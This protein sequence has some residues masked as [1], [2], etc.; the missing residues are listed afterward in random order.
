MF[1]RMATNERFLCLPV[2]TRASRH[3]ISRKEHYQVPRAKACCSSASPS[4]LILC[5][6][7]RLFSRQSSEPAWRTGCVLTEATSFPSHRDSFCFSASEIPLCLCPCERLSFSHLS[8][9][10]SNTRP[11]P[12]HSLGFRV[13]PKTVHRLHLD[14]GTLLPCPMAVQ[15]FLPFLPAEV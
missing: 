13:Y 8:W 7:E 5:P 12:V 4:P 3:R 14:C 2:C 6:C 10:K 15:A 11:S 1:G 9:L